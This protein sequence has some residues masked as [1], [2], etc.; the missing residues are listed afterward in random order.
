LEPERRDEL[1]RIVAELKDQK[2]PPVHL[3][4]PSTTRDIDLEIDSNGQWHYLGTPFKRLDIV[5]LLSGLLVRE[6]DAYFLVSPE[7]KLRIRVA[8]VPFLV[9]DFDILGSGDDR[10]I[11][12]DTSVGFKVS[13]DASHPITMRHVSGSDGEI[14]YVRVRD[15]LEARL[16]RSV[17]YRLVA[18]G[19]ARDVDGRTVFGIESGG[20]F[21]A[22]GDV[23]W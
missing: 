15:N 7:E 12:F 20:I 23:S 3:W 11:I 9:V 4:R 1:E 6:D 5:K 14:P 2:L 21:H 18:L 16:T 13:L 19:G 10:Q 17:F 8:D 22:L